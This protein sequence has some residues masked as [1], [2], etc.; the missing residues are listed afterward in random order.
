MVAD[1]GA[2]SVATMQAPALRTRAQLRVARVELQ[3]GDA[4]GVE[5]HNLLLQPQ[6]SG[7][8]EFDSGSSSDGAS[9]GAPKR[10]NH[11]NDQPASA[12]DMNAFAQALSH[13]HVTT[14]VCC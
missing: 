2:E 7:V 14:C 6:P 12:F 9:V 11:R 3:D 8:S 10:A 13:F 4:A 1:V 5:L